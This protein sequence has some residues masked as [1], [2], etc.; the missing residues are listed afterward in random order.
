MDS[1]QQELDSLPDFLSNQLSFD[2]TILN[3]VGTLCSVSHKG[4][5]GGGGGGGGGI[6]AQHCLLFTVFMQ[7]RIVV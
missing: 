3:Q 1:H 6:G 7:H 2:P 4:R 5:R